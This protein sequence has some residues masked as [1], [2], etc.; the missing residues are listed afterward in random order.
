MQLTFESPLPERYSKHDVEWYWRK[1]I[2]N[3][4]KQ[5]FPNYNNHPRSEYWAAVERVIDIIMKRNKIDEIE[6]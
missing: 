1:E 5:S 6:E 3:E 4:I 2:S